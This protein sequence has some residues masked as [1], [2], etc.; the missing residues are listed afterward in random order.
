[1]LQILT[2][3]KK[4]NESAF[5][6]ITI[7]IF[8]VKIYTWI[9]L[10]HLKRKF[11][12]TNSQKFQ[13][14]KFSSYVCGNPYFGWY[15]HYIYI[16]IWFCL[17]KEGLIHVDVLEKISCLHAI[18]YIC[19]TYNTSKANAG[20]WVIFTYILH[21]IQFILLQSKISYNATFLS[22]YW[23]TLTRVVYYLKLVE[24]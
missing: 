6:K 9:V 24:Y 22:A 3:F 4:C 11:N 14:L 21:L 16:C 12:I 1:M 13:S 20:K 19:L 10:S 2:Y 18:C 17:P 8:M 23:A 7:L 15:T 5:A